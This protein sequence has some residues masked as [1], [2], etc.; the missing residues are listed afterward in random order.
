MEIDMKRLGLVLSGAMLLG[1]VAPAVIVAPAGAQRWGNGYRQTRPY[2]DRYDR[3]RYRDD[4]RS[5]GIGPGTGALIGGGAGAL[6]GGVLGGGMKGALIGGA[7]GAGGGA[8]LGKANQNNRRRD[9][10]DG[11]RY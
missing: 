9:W 11:R 5:G 10:R 8:L 4:H 1:A 6:L 7:V 3:G 2:D